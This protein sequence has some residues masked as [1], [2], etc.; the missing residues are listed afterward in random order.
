MSHQPPRATLGRATLA[1]A[2]LL[3]A[4]STA[5]PA[6]FPGPPPVLPSGARK[7]PMFDGTTGKAVTWEALVQRA[8]SA[9][10]VLIGELH[11]HPAGLQAAAALFDDLLAA[12]P[13]GPALA[14]EFFERDSQ[15][16]IDDFADGIIDEKSFVRLA[17][18]TP[19]NYPPGHR[20]MVLAAIEAGRPVL[21]A[22]AP[23]RYVTLARKKGLERLAGFGPER[24]PLVAV[25]DALTAGEYR[26][27]FEQTMHGDELDAEILESFFRS[28]N[29]WDA[30]MADTVLSA[31]ANGAR[32]AVL[33]VGRFH[34]GHD[35]GT[36]QRIRAAEPELKLF[37]IA[38]DASDADRLAAN[39]IALG[40]VVIYAGDLPP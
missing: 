4:C 36:A 23:R 38:I 2:A 12:R 20:A 15:L 11:G 21:A 35:G 24:A 19:G 39:D 33:V 40:D 29:L 3:A 37:T 8:L 16:L 25:P 18:R 10:V 14:L 17:R 34:V 27:R 7:L 31:H 30:T 9:D 32:P 5:P 1:L 13:D 22:N 28:Q 26:R 6:T